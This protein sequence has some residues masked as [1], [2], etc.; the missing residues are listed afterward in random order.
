MN[1]GVPDV[2]PPLLL[3]AF[4]LADHWFGV[5]ARWVKEV[6]GQVSFTPAP[7]A[8]PAVRGYVNLRGS[9][10][11]ALDLRRLWAN[12]A[13]SADD[14][15]HLLVFKPSAGES[16]ALVAEEVA[17]IAAVDG[18]RMEDARAADPS[19]PVSPTEDRLAALAIG[20]AKLPNRLVTVLDPRRLLDIAF[21]DSTH[22]ARS[23]SIS[24]PPPFQAGRPPDA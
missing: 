10:I 23:S 1:N 3:C 8:P 9:L 18:R 2:P 13:P 19:L 17:E 16:F 22:S 15:S 7:H 20:F 24:S 14:S 12:T 4:R 21:A 5:E 6:S 11:L